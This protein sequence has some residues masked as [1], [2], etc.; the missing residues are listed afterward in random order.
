MHKIM[1][2]YMKFFEQ[3]IKKIQTFY[4]EGSLQSSQDPATVLYPQPYK[5]NRNPPL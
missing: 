5:S 2:G 3:L 1:E 4:P